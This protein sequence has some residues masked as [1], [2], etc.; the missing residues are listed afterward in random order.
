MK[1]LSPKM[2]RLLGRYTNALVYVAEVGMRDAGLEYEESAETFK[3]A[4]Q[5]LLDHLIE[6]EELR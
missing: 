5:R 1:K 3:K 6:L 2:R 4:E